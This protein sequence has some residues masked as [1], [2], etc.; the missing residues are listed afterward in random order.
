MAGNE[1]V[2]KVTADV[3]DV[4]DASRQIGQAGKNAGQEFQQGFAAND[5]ILER[6]RNQLKELNQG[7]DGNVTTI[8]GLKAKLAELGQTLDKSTIG[9]KEFVAAQKEIAQTQEKLN[10]ALKG[11]SGSENSIQ[12]L[13]NKLTELNGVLQKAEIGSKEFVASQKEIAQ[14]Q[15]KLNAALKGFNGSENSIQGLNNKLSEL[16]GI[17]QKA[18]IGSKEFAAAQKEITQT[19][20]KLNAALKGFSGNDKSIEGLN[21]KLAEYNSILQKAEIGSKEFVTAQKQIAKTQQEVN[22]ALRG[23]DGSENTI[24]GLRAR[25]DELNKTLD[26][27]EINSKEFA[28]AQKEIAKTQNEVDKALGGGGGIIKGLGQELKS[29][30]LQAG[31]FLSVGA[32]LQFIGKE[33]VE[34]DKASAAVRTLGVSSKELSERLLNLS[35]ELGSNISRVELMKASYDVASSGFSK[36][37]EIVDILRASALGASGGFAELGDVTKAVTGVINAYGLTTEDATSIV[38]GFVQTQADGVITVREYAA[39]IGTVASVAAAAGIPISELNAAIATATLKGV[40]VEQAFTGIRQAITSILKPSAEATALAN[41]L[42]ISFNLSGLEA[43]GF[44]GLLADVQLKT[45]GA[46]DKLAILLGSVEAQAAVQPIVN[47]DLKKY[48]ELL[49]NQ[50]SSSGAAAKSSKEATDTIAGGFEKVKNAASNLATTLNTALPG[51]PALFTELARVIEV[52]VKVLEAAGPAIGKSF[53]QAFTPFLALSKMTGLNK[54]FNDSID[55]L[56]KLLAGN[57]EVTAEQGKQETAV[58]KVTDKT[59]EQSKLTQDILDTAKEQNRNDLIRLENAQRLLDANSKLA[60]AQSD[61]QVQIGQAGI[62][63]GDALV[64]LEDSRYSIV[65]NRNKYELEAAKNRGASEAEL[66]GIKRRG[67]EIGDTHQGRA[68][69]GNSKNESLSH[70]ME[71]A[72]YRRFINASQRLD[73][74]NVER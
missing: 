54:L 3:R 4:L 36:T 28:A 29:F 60:K 56:L 14:T 10:A 65:I 13:T 71:R 26:Q 16:N 42:G 9:S 15:E 1:W 2:I 74:R 30:A 55:W 24:R 25:L 32:A 38:D 39:Q 22:T 18:E 47:D 7:I 46:A 11:F 51:V 43:R 61:A 67:E 59:K 31:A 37:S 66:N 27:T 44:G 12:G 63:L 33:I 45:G 52:A 41:S 20:E 70:I 6:M 69:S 68:K 21:N 8:G 49:G 62:N 5:K 64:K 40:P 73:E 17:L 50:A 48:N 35:I 19:Q 23:F 72:Y 34:L 58:G 57:K 53:E